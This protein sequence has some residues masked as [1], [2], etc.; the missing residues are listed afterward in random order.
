MSYFTETFELVLEKLDKDTLKNAH[1]NGLQ[2]AALSALHGPAGGLMAL[3]YPAE[4]TYKSIDGKEYH[5]KAARDKWMNDQMRNKEY[6]YFY[7]DHVMDSVEHQK[8]VKDYYKAKG[9]KVYFKEA[10]DI[11]AKMIANKDYNL[12]KHKISWFNVGELKRALNS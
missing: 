3:K 10:D 9:C 6:M 4:L 5:G 7:K 8:K 11:I 1:K 2:G 12:N